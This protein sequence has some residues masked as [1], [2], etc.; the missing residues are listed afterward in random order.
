VANAFAI[1]ARPQSLA[2]YGFTFF[3]TPYVAGYNDVIKTAEDAGRWARGGLGE[4]D[5]QAEAKLVRTLLRAA[6]RDGVNVVL[7]G[8]VEKSLNLLA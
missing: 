2:I 5:P 4:H 6:D 8:G 1:A 7:G 3:T